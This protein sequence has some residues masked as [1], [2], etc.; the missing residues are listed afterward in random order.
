MNTRATL[1]ARPRRIAI[2]NMIEK[3]LDLICVY[4]NGLPNILGRFLIWEEDEHRRLRSR[5]VPEIFS[6]NRE[7][8]LSLGAD[9]A[10]S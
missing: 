6:A 4:F 5:L 3:K 10:L 2:L 7:L 1:N 9:E 8:E